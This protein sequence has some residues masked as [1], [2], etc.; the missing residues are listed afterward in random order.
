M[1]KWIGALL[2]SLVVALSGCINES[3]SEGEIQN[4]GDVLSLDNAN[5][6]KSVV[7]SGGIV[8]YTIK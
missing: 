3:S 6:E 1:K 2:L 5:L 8:F 7:R 4:Y